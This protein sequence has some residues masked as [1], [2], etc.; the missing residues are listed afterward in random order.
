MIYD[1]KLPNIQSDN[2]YDFQKQVND[3]L[4]ILSESI[5]D[6]VNDIST[7]N[8]SSELLA[9]LKAIGADITLDTSKL[10]SH[11][12]ST[13]VNTTEFKTAVTNIINAQT[14]G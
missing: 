1:I 8:I 11:F 13:L 6:A 4:Y 3:V 9:K 10:K 5:G 2:L 14:G 7:D 12:I